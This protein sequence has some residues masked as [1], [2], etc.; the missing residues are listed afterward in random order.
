VIKRTDLVA[1]ARIGRAGRRACALLFLLAGATS[2]CGSCVHTPGPEALEAGAAAV[3]PPVP[4]PDGLLA[5]VW[6]RSPDVAWASLQRG[7]GGAV[8]LLPSAA[9][10]IA[11]GY[12]GLDSRL[13][14]FIDGRATAYAVV[15]D[16]G[17]RIAWTVALPLSDAK[18][19]AAL[20]LDAGAGGP[21]R[22]AGAMRVLAGTDGRPL[23]A[24]AALAGRWLLL[25]PTEGDLLRLGPYAYRTM[26]TLAAPEGSAAIVA[27]I[28]HDALEG[29]LSSRLTSFWA[30]QRAWLATRD[31]E[32]R[33]R[34]GGRA[35][36]FG[37]PRAIL[38]AAD[39]A[40]KRRLDL[41]AHAR[42][43][44][45]EIAPGDDEVHAE[46]F[47][48][49]GD[50]PGGADLVAALPTGDVVPLAQAPADAVL[51]LF[52]RDEAARR[53][54]GVGELES[55]IDGVLGGR[56]G[57]DDLRAAH[58]AIEDWGQ[59]R[60]DWWCAAVS[61]GAAEP[62]HGLWVRT[63]ATDA[64]RSERAVR[65]LVNLPRRHAFGDLLA[66]TLHVAPATLATADVPSFGRA[67]LA[68]FAW[69]EPN[70]SARRAASLPAGSPPAVA[71]GVH[72]GDL[73]LAAGSAAP[74]LLSAAAAPPRRLGDDPANARA[75]AALGTDAA[76]AV[77]AQP[78]RLLGDR[79]GGGGPPVPAILAWGR[80]QG[81]AWMRLE[82]A[83][84]L[85]RE[86]L[87]LL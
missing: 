12:A 68:T 35:P 13:S 6:L 59:G 55:V 57:A 47:L 29:R 14:R 39:A 86:L 5:Q 84:P 48:D 44:R 56:A 22:E 27:T 51:A 16:A 49:P 58:A 70:A 45:I 73:M 63:P 38:A 42:R 74:A 66:G 79:F 2:G 85:L 81:T 77:F 26:P 37:D 82:L 25:A 71:W 76:F 75:L 80:K 4:A 10:E 41:V 19:A 33:A 23:A 18:Q 69:L 15:G 60:R 7:V 30:E 28:G 62:S 34:H 17:S 24:S 87:R 53:A 36:D 54:D 20:L 8:A 72:D 67:S 32:Q 52:S 11:C 21:E 46:L 40:V 9:G 64:E 65:E 61:W 83:D 1:A 78:L 43:A 50:D 31:D 3:E